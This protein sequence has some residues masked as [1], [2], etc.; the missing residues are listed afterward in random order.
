[1]GVSKAD[2]AALGR[3]GSKTVL[4]TRDGEVVDRADKVLI[5]FRPAFQ[6]HPILQ[7]PHVKVYDLAGL[8][9]FLKPTDNVAPTIHSMTGV[10]PE[11]AEKSAVLCFDIMDKL[12]AHY[13][14]HRADIEPYLWWLKSQEVFYQWPWLDYL[15]MGHNGTNPIDILDIID[16]LKKVQDVQFEAKNATSGTENFRPSQK[17]YHDALVHFLDPKT[18]QKALLAQGGTGVGKTRAYLSAALNTSKTVW[19]STFTKTLQEQVKSEAINIFDANVAIRKGRN[20]YLCLKIFK[21]MIDNIGALSDGTQHV[22]LMTMMRWISMTEDG[23]ITGADFPAWIAQLYGPQ[24]TLY[25]TDRLRECNYQGCPFFERC[26]AEIA[27]TKAEQSDLVVTNHAMVSSLLQYRPNDL[28]DTLIMDEAHHVS[29]VM[30]DTFQTGFS[31]VS[32]RSMGVFLYGTASTERRRGRKGFIESLKDHLEAEDHDHIH[33]VNRAGQ[34]L[35]FDHPDHIEISGY[36]TDIFDAVQSAY[37]H[38]RGSYDHEIARELLPSASPELI[39][40]LQK[41]YDASYKLFKRME[42][43]EKEMS[44][45]G[46]DDP[47]IDTK[48]LLFE[49]AVLSPLR[50]WITQLEQLDLSMPENIIE[51]GAIKRLDGQVIDHGIYR[52]FLDPVQAWHKT[53]HDFINKTIY[54]TATKTP[55]IEGVSESSIQVESPFDY[56][57]HSK[58]I[59]LQDITV[60]SLQEVGQ[61]ILNLS[62]ASNGGA[63]GV[64]TA[65]QNLKAA[66]QYIE[67]YRN[68][69]DLNVI[70]Q[71]IDPIDIGTLIQLFKNEPR[72]LLLGTDAVRDGVDIPGKSLQLM[73]FDRVPWSRPNMVHKARMAHHGGRY[74]EEE[75][76]RLRLR[77]AYGR[78]IRSETDKGIFVMLDSK[79]PSRLYDAFPQG[80]SIEKMTLEE[81]VQSVKDFL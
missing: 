3:Y 69:F 29:G 25:S 41:F 73:M 68:D 34:C 13:N 59:I 40:R 55:N 63:L 36:L 10:M 44:D 9:A 50:G 32:L 66:H 54:T 62:N 19:V 77:Q 5:L 67:A 52:A 20:N 57:N 71:H 6:N 15:E 75:Q 28:P 53:S 80:V 24:H 12:L 81:A 49:R 56:I 38:K 72:S 64:F 78:L 17:T 43:R 18:D 27:R 39:E 70:A 31:I 33:E 16:T 47:F 30:D 22:A 37:G 8:W 4:V 35:Q 46:S 51:W 58:I 45:K 21:Q 65:I 1:M 76:V 14:D 42:L 61:A 23:D 2:F 74:Y 26:F 11:S 79:L 48:K 7:N 60:K